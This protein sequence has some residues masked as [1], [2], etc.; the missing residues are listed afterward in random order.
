MGVVCFEIAGLPSAGADYLAAHEGNRP[1]WSRHRPE[2]TWIAFVNWLRGSPA[3]YRYPREDD[4][5][6]LG[7]YQR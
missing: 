5:I 6:D 7:P 4:D 2:H 3:G 1:Y